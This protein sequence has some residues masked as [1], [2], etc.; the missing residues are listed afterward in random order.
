MTR[1]PAS[2]RVEYKHRTSRIGL[3]VDVTNVAHV[4]DLLDDDP[5]RDREHGPG[6]RKTVRTNGDYGQSRARC[7][8]GSP[9][10]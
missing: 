4:L 1:E 7:A 8:T 5:A 2:E 6:L 9:C 10:C 3:K